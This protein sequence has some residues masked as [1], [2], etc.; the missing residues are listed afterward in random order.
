MNNRFPTGI[1]NL[2][3]ITLIL[4]LAAI[5][6]ASYLFIRIAVSAFGP[7]WLVAFRLVVS[8]L[9]LLAV[10]VLIGKRPQFRSTWWHYALL[11]A[12]NAAIP[13]TLV[14]IS[15][16]NLNA[17]I[18]SIINAFTPLSTAIVAAI[19]IKDAITPRKA[20][21]LLM[22]MLGVFVLVGFSP[23]PVTS[24][25]ILSACSSLV[26]TMCYGVGAVYTRVKFDGES[27]A[28][29]TIAQQL[30]GFA[31]QLPVALAVSPL[32]QLS[33]NVLAAAV[34]LALLST[35]F[36]YLI[37]FKLIADLG[38]S[39]GMT[40]IFVVPFF[41]LLWGVVFL[42]EPLTGGIFAGLAIILV[43]VALVAVKPASPRAVSSRAIGRPL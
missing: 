16:G 32:P 34:A 33:P 10:L 13:F 11:G 2:K 4:L 12:V 29:L 35:S 39:R 8:G 14:S 9:A 19:W 43:A 22:G 36:A 31:L 28:A 5:W 26:A 27:P 1:L 24:T 17:S 30:G 18:A 23:I 3:S 7:L 37:Y 38:P 15:V 6:G 41:S 40:V 21:G 42:G 20:I 25:V